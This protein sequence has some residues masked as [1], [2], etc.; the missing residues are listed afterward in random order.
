MFEGTTIISVRRGDSVVVAGDG[1]VTFG[2][3]TVMKH[4]ARKVRRIHDDQVLCGFAGSTADAIT[5]YEKLEEKLRTYGGNL[6]RAAVELAKEWRTDRALRRLEALLIAA[7]ARH[8]L[9]IS[10]TGDVID[11]EEGVCAIGSG[12]SYALAAARSLMR[13][14]EMS[15][16]AIAEESLRIAAE[17]CVFTND[18]LTVERLDADSDYEERGL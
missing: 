7:D 15:A 11:P 5:L 14:T 10:G 3:K 12:G 4:G 8:T 17:I 6:V 18:E 16:E 13:H 1:Q 9:V 2:E